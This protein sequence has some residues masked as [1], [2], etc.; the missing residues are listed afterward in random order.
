MTLQTTVAKFGTVMD[1]VAGVENVRLRPGIP[2]DLDAALGT[3]DTE[4]ENRVQR[5]TLFYAP[6]GVLGAANANQHI[7]LDFTCVVE[8]SYRE[9][10]DSYLDMADRIAAVMLALLNP[11]SGFCQIDENGIS[12]L[13]TPGEPVK[14]ETGHAVYRASF[15]GHLLDVTST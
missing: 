10:D 12:P 8:W 11:T 5:W 2:V 4:G 15:S 13:E 1:S 3:L 7:E 6:S 9:D 14:T